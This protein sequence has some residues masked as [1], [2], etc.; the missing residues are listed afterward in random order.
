MP[1]RVHPLPQN[2][3]SPSPRTFAATG[4]K[5]SDLT[6]GAAKEIFPEDKREAPSYYDIHTIPDFIDP[7]TYDI[8]L[9]DITPE[10]W[11]IVAEKF[12]VAR[13]SS[14]DSVPSPPFPV[15]GAIVGW[16]NR[17]IAN[18]VCQRRPGAPLFNFFFLVDTGSPYT[19]LSAE[20]IAVLTG[21]ATGNIPTALT[22]NIQGIPSMG[23]RISPPT[24]HFADVDVLGMDFMRNN[25]A[26]ISMDHDKSE[27]QL[28]IKAQ[29]AQAGAL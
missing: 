3:L 27:F 29:R 16:C 26:S 12:S 28:S 8:M 10:D 15:Q 6:F 9:T 22:V 2:T 23:C 18:F 25:Y 11:S 20:T 17:L 7:A 21:G 19:F 13:R 5:H 4:L 1:L 14:A 24:S